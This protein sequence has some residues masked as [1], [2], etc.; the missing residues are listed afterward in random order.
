MRLDKQSRLLEPTETKIITCVGCG[1]QDKCKIIESYLDTD[2][3]FDPRLG[4]ALYPDIALVEC[5]ACHMKSVICNGYHYTSTCVDDEDAYPKNVLSSYKEM[6]ACLNTN[7]YTSYAMMCRRILM[8]V[9]I[10]LGAT[11]NKSFQH[12]VKYLEN[13]GCVTSLMKKWVEHIRKI[14]NR[15]NHDCEPVS[16]RHAMFALM[17]IVALITKVY[18][19]RYDCLNLDGYCGL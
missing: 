11:E 5:R 10:N 2:T 18:A 12:Y 3:V 13:Y 19:M 14:G 16:K 1:V 17:F 7:S 15:A 9:A 6:M 8:L 4:K